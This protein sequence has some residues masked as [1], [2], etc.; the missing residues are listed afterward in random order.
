M[1]LTKY[2]IAQKLFKKLY[3]SKNNAKTIV[4]S[5]FKEILSSLKKGEKVKLS[6]FGKFVLKHKKKES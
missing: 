2:K 6:G 3:I 1:T 5:F 4:E